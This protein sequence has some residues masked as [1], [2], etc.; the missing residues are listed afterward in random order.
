MVEVEQASMVG[1]TRHLNLD[2]TL[3]SEF[4]HGLENHLTNKQQEGTAFPI[5]WAWQT[6]ECLAEF[7][8]MCET[9]QTAGPVDLNFDM[10]FP[11]ESAGRDDARLLRNGQLQPRLHCH[12]G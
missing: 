10:I 2:T 12:P 5:P 9:G 3:F 1:Q 6:P 4:D 7:S 8:Q 11:N